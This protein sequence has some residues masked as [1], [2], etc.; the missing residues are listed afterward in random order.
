MYCKVTNFRPVLIFVLSKSAKFNT[1]RKF[2]LV[3]RP[4][5]FNEILSRGHWNVWRL[6]LKIREMQ[7]IVGQASDFVEVVSKI[8]WTLL[9]EFWWISLMKKDRKSKVDWRATL[10]YVFFL[11]EFAWIHQPTHEFDCRTS[12]GCRC[13]WDTHIGG[14]AKTRY[15][16]GPGLH[17]P[18]RKKE[19]VE[20]TLQSFAASPEL[21][22][23]RQE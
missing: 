18:V 16:V 19:N 20:E 7:G 9:H 21:E 12:S 3:L 13:L 6:I 23:E 8:D 1:V 15:R 14:H 2:L 5:N 11:R 17:L 4:S 22:C 10:W